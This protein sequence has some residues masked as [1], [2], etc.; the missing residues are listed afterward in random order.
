MQPRCCVERKFRGPR[1]SA[2]CADSAALGGARSRRRR[3]CAAPDGAA[4]PQATLLDGPLPDLHLA[5]FA[6]EARSS[7]PTMDLIA[8][9]GTFA[10]LTGAMR[11]PRCGASYSRYC[12]RCARKHPR[13]QHQST[14][15]PAAP[16]PARVLPISARQSSPRAAAHTPSIPEL[17]ASVRLPELI[18]NSNR[19]LEVSR[20][21]RLVASG[22]QRYSSRDRRGPGRRSWRALSIA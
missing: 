9:D 17:G 14:N 3:G 11:S 12:G 1:P 21:I 15:N 13:P 22:G 20:R 8:L 10:G 18:G 6:E 7:Q 2:Q 19:M 5:D 4:R 16:V